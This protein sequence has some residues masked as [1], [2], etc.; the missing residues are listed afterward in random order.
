MA[1]YLPALAATFGVR[2][3]EV[4][5]LTYRELGVLAGVLDERERQAALP[6]PAPDGPRPARHL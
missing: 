1:R 6:P 5:R 3:W 2:P 4:D